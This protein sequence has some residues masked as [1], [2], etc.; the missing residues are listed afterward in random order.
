MFDDVVVAV[1]PVVQNHLLRL[2][3]LAHRMT[4]VSIE[5]KRQFR[6]LRR[7]RTKVNEGAC[8]EL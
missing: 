8:V 1:L 7:V 5:L 4:R 3:R 6:A 2:R